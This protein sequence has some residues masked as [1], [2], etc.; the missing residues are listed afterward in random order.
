MA[1]GFC[2]YLKNALI[3]QLHG[4]AWTQPTTVYVG[5]CTSV[6]AAGVITGEPSGNGYTRVAVANTSTTVWGS[7]SSGTISN[8]NGSIKFP[9]CI[10]S[11]WGTV[12]TFF[13]SDASSGNTNTLYWGDLTSPLAVAVND[14]PVFNTGELSATIN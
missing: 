7:P 10:T 12:T 5:L 13:V 2:T 14:Q 8:V 11:G 4:A 9:Q 3:G 6:S 1:S